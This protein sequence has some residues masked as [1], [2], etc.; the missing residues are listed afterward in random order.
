MILSANLVILLE[1]PIQIPKTMTLEILILTPFLQ[2][3][4]NPNLNNQ[5]KQ[6]KKQ[7]LNQFSIL[8]EDLLQKHLQLRTMKQ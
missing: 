3:S 6:H 2:L 4:T 7:Q 1:K 8:L 5:A